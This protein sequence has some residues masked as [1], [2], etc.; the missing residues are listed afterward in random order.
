MK[1]T[2]LILI[3]ARKGSKDNV[4]RQNLRLVN[5]KPL[6]YYIMN[7]AKKYHSADVF[8]STESEEL[9]EIALLN[10]VKIIKRPKSLIGDST[11]LEEISYHA[12]TELKKMNKDYKKCL[13][14]H[15]K[16]PLIEVNTINRFFSQIDKRKK[17]FFGF[18][19]NSEY[20]FQKINSKD[21]RLLSLKN[22]NYD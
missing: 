17:I 10:N 11:T 20:N 9:Q 12:L 2:N 4:S 8:V 15:P 1:K 19:S 18:T 3:I 13:V 7:T 16:F 21:H 22:N 14:L 6:I 5:E